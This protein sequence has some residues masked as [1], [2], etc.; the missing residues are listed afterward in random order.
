ML[1]FDDTEEKE[2]PQIIQEIPQPEQDTII[3]FDDT[4]PEPEQIPVPKY[5]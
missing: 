5:G 4:E 2:V 3:C 1:C